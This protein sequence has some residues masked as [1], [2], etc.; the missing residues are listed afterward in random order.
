MVSKKNMHNYVAN[1]GKEAG[2]KTPKTYH[3]QANKT[4]N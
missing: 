1:I 4:Y 2:K 3:M